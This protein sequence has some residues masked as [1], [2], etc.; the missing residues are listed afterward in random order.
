MIPLNECLRQIPENEIIQYI[1][2]P[3]SLFGEKK[4][5]AAT[6]AGNGMTNFGIDNDDKLFFY[7]DQTP[8]PGDI[9][10]VGVDS[11]APMIRQLLI[12]SNASSYLLHAS[13]AEIREDISTKEPQIYGVLAYV[14]KAIKSSRV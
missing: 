1:D 7:K 11:H 3:V 4:L 9:V 12:N 2:L 6:A 13:G 5:F 14:L 10:L 8:K